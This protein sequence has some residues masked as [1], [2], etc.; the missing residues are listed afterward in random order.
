MEQRPL[1][2]KK[3]CG[4][5]LG[6]GSNQWRP[7]RGGGR[8][9]WE[10]REVLQVAGRLFGIDMR[11]VTGF[12]ASQVLLGAPIQFLG[13]KAARQQGSAGECPWRKEK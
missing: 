11:S 12:V 10:K 6:G 4:K 1:L 9:V 7:E 2:D 13:Q 8:S 3:L 5:A